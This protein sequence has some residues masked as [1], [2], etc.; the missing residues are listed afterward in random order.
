MVVV[1]LEIWEFLGG[2][3]EFVGARVV[4]GVRGGV[5]LAVLAVLRDRVPQV[6]S[7]SH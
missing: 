7:S 3:E 6:V 5:A 1:F 2:F 4:L